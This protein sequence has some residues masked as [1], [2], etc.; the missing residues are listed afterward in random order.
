[1]RYLATD[2]LLCW[3]PPT[4][5]MENN[6]LSEGDDQGEGLREIQKRLAQPI[7]KFLTANVWPGAELRPILGPDSI[8][9]LSQ[10]AET[11]QIIEQWLMQL[12]PFE[13]AGLE[14]AFLASKSLIIATRLVVQWSEAFKGLWEFCSTEEA[15]DIEQAVVASSSE[16][17]WQTDRW[18][19]VED[20]HDVNG[21]D[22]R[23][24]LGSVVVLVSGS[25]A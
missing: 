5:A 21:E 6:K 3:D 17:K 4:N 2:S 1:M 15:F 25:D 20:S 13:L 19:E 16:T 10:P 11:S 24:Q 8:L 14:R 12:L 7:I 22:L 18:G 23:R 9:P